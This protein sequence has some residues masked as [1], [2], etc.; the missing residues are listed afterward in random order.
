[1]MMDLEEIV[2]NF[3]NA[4][5]SPAFHVFR[6]GYVGRESGYNESGVTGG[7]KLQEHTQQTTH[8]TTCNCL[9]TSR[10]KKETWNC[11]LTC[12]CLKPLPNPLNLQPINSGCTTH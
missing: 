5:D 6:Q 10:G 8:T 3:E 2:F 7:A 9:F 12:H 1:M 4:E 11:L